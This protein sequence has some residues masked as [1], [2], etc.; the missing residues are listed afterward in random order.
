LSFASAA[1]LT[2]LALVSPAAAATTHT[3]GRHP[4]VHAAVTPSPTLRALAAAYASFRH[5]PAGDVTGVRPGTV[6]IAYDPSTKTRWATASFFPSARASAAVLLGFQDSGSTGVFRRPGSAQWKMV[7]YGS[8]PVASCSASLPAAVR[9]AWHASSSECSQVSRARTRSGQAASPDVS[10]A[11]DPATIADVAQQ[12]VGVGDTPASTSFSRDCNPFTA[13]VGVGASTSGC[14]VD[15]TFGV[16]D[17]N[18]EWCADFAKWVWEQGGVTAG[19][20]TLDP[21]SASFYQWAID[22]GQNPVFDSG[23]PQVGDAIVF[24]PGSDTAPNAT[25]ADHVGLV[26]GVNSNGTLNLA[27]GDFLGSS[28]ITVQANTTSP[29]ISSWAASIWGTGEQWIYVS[30]AGGETAFQANTGDQ[31]IYTPTNTGDRDTG[32]GMAAGTSPAIA[33]NGSGGFETALQAN[34]G[35]LWIDTPTGNVDTSLGMAAGTSPAIADSSSGFETAF[36]ANTDDLWIYTPGNAGNRDT[37]L[38]MAA[39]TS[40]AIA[41]DGS[42]FEVAF[43]ADT[44]DLWLHTPTG[45]VDTGLGMAAGTSPAIAPDGSGFEVAFQADTGDLWIDTPTGNVDTGL[46]MAAGTSPAIVDGEVAFQ[47]NTGDLWVYTPTNTGDRNTA[48]GMA[49]KTSPAI[50]PDGEVAFQAN[51]GDLWI[52]TPTNAGDRNTALGMAAA[53]S[54]AITN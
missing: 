1:A 22:Q 49:A 41:P 13:M 3:S 18:E 46:G 14:G 29:S 38:G 6:R 4:A 30:P 19:L 53:T 33:P 7:G 50:A 47:A 9:R 52:Y 43:Q 51:T 54:P 16:Q 15:P 28:N 17:E 27:N 5:I 21:S 24:Y 37:G 26:V 23:T 12:N 40:P 2:V 31:W 42:G 10:G 44:G 48:L 32:L 36:Q 25:Y 45:N 8:Q 35:D 34:T 20:S 11:A 39:K